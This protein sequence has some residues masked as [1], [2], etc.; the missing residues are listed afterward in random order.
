[1][2]YYLRIN[3]YLSRYFKELK[4][5]SEELSETMKDFRLK[6]GFYE[7]NLRKAFELTK[8][9][10]FKRYNKT[11][12]T[13]EIYLDY[14]YKDDEMKSM[15]INKYGMETYN[16][17]LRAGGLEEKP[18]EATKTNELKEDNDL[19]SYAKEIQEHLF[20]LGCSFTPAG[21]VS[22]TALMQDRRPLDQAISFYIDAIVDKYSQFKNT[23][24]TV[25]EGETL[26]CTASNKLKSIMKMGKYQNLLFR[27]PYLF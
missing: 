5:I 1:M 24:D 7:K 9:F 25:T 23:I 14:L 22:A 8:K 2:F 13:Y 12:L 15:I 21:F 19:L 16:I 10:Q 3:Y 27:P 20:D 4:S 18:P 6:A 17:F 11:T 26:I